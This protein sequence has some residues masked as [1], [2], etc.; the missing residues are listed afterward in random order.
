MKKAIFLPNKGSQATQVEQEQYKCIT[1]LLIFSMV[2]IRLDIAFAMLVV[3]CFAKNPFWQHIKAIK[4]IMQ[5]LKT[6]KILSIKYSKNE[7]GDLIIKGYSNSDWTSDYATKK[8][9]L[10]FIFMLNGG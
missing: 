1:R 7:R 8:S 2:K 10:E 6:T 5:Y 4:T 3:S 9:I